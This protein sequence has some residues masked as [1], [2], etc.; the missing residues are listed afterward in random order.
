MGVS[1]GVVSGSCT[2]SSILLVLYP[3]Q[4]ANHDLTWSIAET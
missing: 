1:T 3:N 2:C 4:L